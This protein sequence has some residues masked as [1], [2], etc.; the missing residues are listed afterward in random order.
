MKK[1]F[2]LVELLAVIVIIGIVF[3]L[4]AVNIS[5]VLDRA[6]ENQYAMVSTMVQE[7][8]QMYVDTEKPVELDMIGG[9]YCVTLQNLYDRGLIDLPLINP[10]TNEAFETYTCVYVENGSEGLIFDFDRSDDDE[11]TIITSGLIVDLPMGD[12]KTG[13]TFNDRSGTGNN[14]SSVGT[15]LV[16]DRFNTANKATSFDGVD[17]LLT[18]TL[19]PPSDNFTFS[20]WVKA[21]TTH[22][23]DYQANTSTSGMVGQKYVIQPTAY[24]SNVGAGIGVSYG[25]NGISV[26]EH[27]GLYL[28]AVTT[29]IS[30]FSTD[31][32]HVTIS[33]YQ[34][35]SYIYINGKLVKVGLA[36]NRPSTFAPTTIGGGSYGY[37]NGYIDDYKLYNR[38]L[39]AT[40]VLHNYNVEK[41]T[42]TKSYIESSPFALLTKETTLTNLTKGGL[43]I[44]LGLGNYSCNRFFMDRTGNENFGLALNAVDEPGLTTDRK[45]RSNKASLFDGVNDSM[46]FFY[47]I[48]TNT[49]TYSIWV[50]AVTTHE[51]DAQSNSSTTGASGQ[52]YAL[53]PDHNGVN[54]GTGLSVGTNGISVYEH[55]DAYLSP[56]LSQ[57][58]AIGTN[59]TQITIVY[60]NKTPSL[61]VNGVFSKTGLA[62]LRTY[63]YSPANIG[64]GPY[65]Y[66]NG[67]MD[68]YH[69]YNRVLTSEEIMQNYIAEL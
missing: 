55:G 6:T 3:A 28:P 19:T 24:A 59:W 35:K 29:F 44:D 49:F 37:F 15:T 33:N 52:K 26:Y 30:S 14:A 60:N 4:A 1:G 53:Y 13:S 25:T 9:L 56:L 38:V 11:D 36:S 48:L 32:A 65:G 5:K 10:K 21:T 12:Y 40:E 69:L 58:V 18:F 42:T 20:F 2:T 39:S 68:E 16:P 50:K 31:W 23:L 46:W 8:A 22:E 43:I 62:S 34:R 64:G 54:A 7:A 63:V 47:P 45:S 61:Y 41:T 57:T 66:F 67:S 51:I 17:D 27:S